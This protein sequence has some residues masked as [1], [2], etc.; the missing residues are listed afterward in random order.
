MLCAK[1]DKGKAKN[2]KPGKAY[3]VD[4]SDFNAEPDFAFQVN[5]SVKGAGDMCIEVSGI[6]VNVLIDS[7]STCH[8]M[9]EKTW[10]ELK[11][12]KISCTSERNEK[13]I[14]GYGQTQPLKTV[15]KCRARVKCGGTNVASENFV[16]VKG[17]AKTLLGR[18]TAERLG[19][20]ESVNIVSDKN[21]VMTV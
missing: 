12:R 3:S 13:E 4:V 2:E 17:E 18:C 6:P 1:T 8:I 15:G 5:S 10:C 7:G 21:D 11:R 19:P 16:V 14:C 9:D 20:S